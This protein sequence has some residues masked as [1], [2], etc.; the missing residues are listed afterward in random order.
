MVFFSDLSESYKY[1]R[2]SFIWMLGKYFYYGIH[3]IPNRVYFLPVLSENWNHLSGHLSDY[4]KRPLFSCCQTPFPFMTDLYRESIGWIRQWLGLTRST[5]RALNSWT[6]S[7]FLCC[8]LSLSLSLKELD[9]DRSTSS[10]RLRILAS[11]LSCFS[12][13]FLSSS[14]SCL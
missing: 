10:V 5:R 2:F 13:S 7:S 12:R 4:W 3:C 14:E 6:A 8:S 9:S 1:H 11:I